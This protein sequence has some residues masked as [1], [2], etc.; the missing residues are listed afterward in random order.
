MDVEIMKTNDE[1]LSYEQ[2]IMILN[3]DS[4]MLHKE[5]K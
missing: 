3:T 5:D 1:S 4:H 2:F